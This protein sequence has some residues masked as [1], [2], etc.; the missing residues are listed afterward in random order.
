MLAMYQTYSAGQVC[1]HKCDKH[2]NTTEFSGVVLQYVYCNLYTA[3]AKYTEA[4]QKRSVC[5]PADMGTS[6]DI[7]HRAIGE[8][9][10]HA[11]KRETIITVSSTH[12]S[13]DHYQTACYKYIYVAKCPYT[14]LVAICVALT[15]MHPVL[16]I[17]KASRGMY[18]VSLQ[19]YTDRQIWL[20]HF[21]I[22]TR[23]VPKAI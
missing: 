11:R 19:L 10:K 23:F 14:E 21:H 6:T 5:L 20:P 3:V 12:A 16:K 15:H 18:K 22:D 8:I 13:I 1:R 2:V 17:I 9:V 7:L 4:V